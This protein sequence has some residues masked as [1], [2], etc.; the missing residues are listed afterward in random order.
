M[1]LNI[2]V[3]SPGPPADPEAGAGDAAFTGCG[4]SGSAGFASVFASW[5]KARRNMPVALSGSG[6][7]GPELELSFFIE[8]RSC[9]ARKAGGLS[10]SLAYTHAVPA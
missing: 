3:N 6:C 10:R 8:K 2:C 1:E 9:S 5:S 7:S 4:A